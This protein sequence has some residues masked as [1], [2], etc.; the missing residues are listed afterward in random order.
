MGRPQTWAWNFD[1]VGQIFSLKKISTSEPQLWKKKFTVNLST[2]IF[3]YF[4]SQLFHKFFFIDNLWWNFLWNGTSVFF[5]KFPGG[6]VFFF[7]IFFRTSELWGRGSAATEP[8][9]LA[10]A[11]WQHF[12]RLVVPQ[13]W[14]FFICVLLANRSL[15]FFLIFFCKGQKNE[16][17]FFSEN[18]EIRGSKVFHSI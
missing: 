16:T 3:F 14:N 18:K 7:E 4:Y 10:S 9:K 8:S 17:S 11:F 1:I 6:R 12:L 15:F 5:E 13:F 2:N